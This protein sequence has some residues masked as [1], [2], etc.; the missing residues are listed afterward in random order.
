MANAIDYVELAVD[1]LGRAKAFYG[2]ALGWT[3]NDYGDDYAGIKDPADASREFGGLNPHSDAPRGGGVLALAR[4]DDVDADL[5][6]VLAAGGRI[7]VELHAYPGGRRFMFAD[8]WD[9]VLGV[10]QP[11]E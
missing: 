1:D 3:F 11:Q 10:Y 8:P 2:D 6:N 5:A 4:T 9:N 7:V